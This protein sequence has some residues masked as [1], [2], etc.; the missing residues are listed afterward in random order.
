[1]LSDSDSISFMQIS[2]GVICVSFH[3]EIHHAIPVVTFVMLTLGNLRSVPLF[4][5]ELQKSGFQN[6][7]SIIGRRLFFSLFQV[8]KDA[9]K[10]GEG[11]IYN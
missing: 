10:V 11:P 4:Y 7:L 5:H 8:A 6:Y 3:Q 2:W 1:M 9:P